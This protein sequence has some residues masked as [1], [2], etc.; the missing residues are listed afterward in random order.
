MRDKGGENGETLVKEYKLLVIRCISSGGLM[1]S[2]VIIAH[3]TV[4]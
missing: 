1:Y 4:L 3:N 2:I